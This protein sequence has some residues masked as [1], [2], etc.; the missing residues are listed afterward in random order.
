MTIVKGR[1]LCCQPGFGGT[2]APPGSALL[3]RWVGA[4]SESNSIF[5]LQQTLLCL[6]LSSSI[7]VLSIC[8]L[9]FERV[10]M[11]E[12]RFPA[13][14]SSRKRQVAGRQ[15]REV[16]RPVTALRPAHAFVAPSA[17]ML[18]LIVCARCL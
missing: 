2:T 7:L 10:K 12:E 3:N 9:R 5:G 1:L 4:P 15:R 18:V 13:P 11:R 8:V 17:H 14:L 16:R 6:R